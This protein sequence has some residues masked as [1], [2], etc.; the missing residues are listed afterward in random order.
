MTDP[1]APDGNNPTDNIPTSEPSTQAT[2]KPA[3]D[4][5]NPTDIP[6]VSSQETD[7]PAIDEDN[8][9]DNIPTHQ[10]N[11]PLKNK[12]YLDLK[13]ILRKLSIGE[14]LEYNFGTRELLEV[15]K[16]SLKGEKPHTM[17]KTF[18]YIISKIIMLDYRFREIPV[19]TAIP[20]NELITDNC[21]DIEAQLMAYSYQ[22]NT[23]IIHP[24]D[25]LVII[26]N[27]CDNLLKQIIVQKLAVCQFAIPI[28]LPNLNSS[29]PLFLSWAM[30]LMDMNWK[31][32]LEEDQ[33]IKFMP[34]VSAMRLSDLCRS[35][36][37]ILNG[38]LC[39]QPHNVYFHRDCEAGNVQRN[40]SNG[41]VEL[42]W[43]IPAGNPEKDNFHKTI[44][45]ANLRGDAKNHS[46]QFDLLCEISSIILLFVSFESISNPEYSS[47]L[48]MLSKSNHELI[49][50][51]LGTV[52][53]VSNEYS[54]QSIKSLKKIMG[55]K[56]IKIVCGKLNGKVINA[57][58][59]TKVLRKEINVCL[60]TES[61]PKPLNWEAVSAKANHIGIEIDEDNIPCQHG[62]IM[63]NTI[64]DKLKLNDIAH[65]KENELPLQGK[66]W[67][68]WSDANKDQAKLNNIEGKPIETY[69]SD[70][71]NEKMKCRKKQF[72][73]V[74]KMTPVMESFIQQITQTETNP[75]TQRY[76]MQWIKI[77]LDNISRI[78]LP[79]IQK[80]YLSIWNDIQV[81]KNKKTNDNTIMEKKQDPE[82]KKLNDDNIIKKQKE[83]DEQEKKLIATSFGMEHFMREVG[84]IYETIIDNK[85]DKSGKFKD[86]YLLP[87]FAARLL[88][89]GYPLEIMDGDVAHV[90][91]TWVK[92]VFES[93]KIILEDKRVYVISV[94][95]IQSS[96]KSTL[97]NTMFGLNFAVS[98]GRCTR[99]VFA[100]LIPVDGELT[101][102]LGYEYILI[103]DTEGLRAPELG[104]LKLNHDNELATLVIGMGDVTLINIKGENTA[105]IED[106]LQI[107]VHAFIRMRKVNKDKKFQPGCYFIHQNVPATNAAEQM[108]YGYIQIQEK[109]NYMAVAAANEEHASNIHSFKDVIDFD[110][111]T[112][113]C[114]FSSLWQGDPPMAPSNPTYS[115]SIMDL[116]THLLRYPSTKNRACL[117]F[118]DLQ[119]RMSDLWQAILFEN[120]VFSF[121]NS[122]EVN[123]Y[124]DLESK[125]SLLS[126]KYRIEVKKWGNDSVN[127]I[128][129]CREEDITKEHSKIKISLGEILDDKLE[130]FTKEL[131][132]FFEGKDKDILVQ[133]RSNMHLKLKSLRNQLENDAT[134]NIEMH[135][136]IRNEQA[137]AK[138]KTASYQ[139]Q[140]ELFVKEYVN[141]NIEENLSEQANLEIFDKKWKEKIETFKFEKIKKKDIEGDVRN[142]LATTFQKE[143]ELLTNTISKFRPFKSEE[144]NLYDI[145]IISDEDFTITIREQLKQSA[146]YLVPIFQVKG[147][148]REV[149]NFTKT[150]QNEVGIYLEENNGL[151]YDNVFLY[152]IYQ[153]VSKLIKDHNKDNK[154][155]KLNKSFEIK[156]TVHILRNVICHF[157][158]LHKEYRMKYDPELFLIKKYKPK[159]QQYFLGAVSQ[160]MKEKT[161]ANMLI[162]HLEGAIVTLLKKDL[163]LKIA[164]SARAS[165][166]KYHTKLDLYNK[167]LLDLGELEEFDE[168]KKFINNSHSAMNNWLK[169]YV[170][171]FC[172]ETVKGNSK[173]VIEADKLLNIT[174]DQLEKCVTDI[175]DSLET[176]DISFKSWYNKYHEAAR[177]IVPLDDTLFN[178]FDENEIK[179]IKYFE[180]NIT[181]GIQRIQKQIEEQFRKWSVNDLDVE[182]HKILGE[183][184][185]GCEKQCPFCKAICIHMK[186]HDVSHSNPCHQPRAIGGYSTVNTKLFVLESC[187]LG[188]AGNRRFRNKATNFKWHN[189]KE[190][191]TVNCEYEKWNI[192]PDTSI[193]GTAYWKWVFVHFKKQ[194]EELHEAKCP[195]L[196]DTWTN[197][198][199]ENAKESLYDIS[200]Y[201]F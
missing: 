15:T 152:N 149:N 33:N 60:N 10:A 59:L 88:I 109:L 175:N 135:F 68:K 75:E 112:N 43:Y 167:I 201:K 171:N 49:F 113:V 185:L 150:L 71:E 37:F 162:T 101:D 80:E 144:C 178:I 170:Y 19:C 115:E 193:E 66:L 58:A 16:T 94:L 17:K 57:A 14:V 174:V 48:Q 127:E 35:K 40:I 32:H 87:L 21:D 124:R 190:Y 179:N 53:L 189:Y 117:T 47:I 36:S 158:L 61:Y 138:I 25:V 145:P 159:L 121:K 198:N 132:T 67:S 177:K 22:N 39:H 92:A 194:F 164:A 83:L 169:N 116:K 82:T 86:L 199:W 28:I 106:I 81:L 6:E 108:A 160:S 163:P 143:P 99:G 133:W 137:A 44:A 34:I 130:F 11:K 148:T 184:T 96:G 64:I 103:L 3:I 2:D 147:T 1:C 191:K 50:I 196:P 91:L 23:N 102:E 76:F 65:I 122:I 192:T 74:E 176:N 139:D 156:V 183:N 128:L 120:F 131:D 168:Y 93:L 111:N 84:Q 18:V 151:D 98:A 154:H 114:Y 166:S 12:D 141:Q 200:K 52:N 55:T 56:E 100:Q 172:K 85:I 13:S 188:V 119:L 45:V 134:M 146:N 20:E 161:A 155:Y 197:L 107:C 157:E 51:F 26:M 136:K 180:E 79:Q 41:S 78:T 182:P 31:T 105:E 153:T 142:F 173:F 54:L 95:G 97:L 38:I 187:H 123:A 195:E 70:M 30:R 165:D 4:E 42:T 62:K 9:T 77:Y 27:S 73:L 126:W 7:K 186:D 90:P 72:K 181:Q 24:S 29:E 125:V 89:S 46:K 104:Q 118:T 140:L 8:P 129:S 5:D 69:I 63:A 110:L